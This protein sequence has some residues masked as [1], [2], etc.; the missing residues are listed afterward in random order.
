MSPSPTGVKPERHSSMRPKIGRILAAGAVALLC[1]TAAGS[2]ASAASQ[3]PVTGAGSTWSS[4]ALEQWI[5]DVN[6][7]GIR[8][9][10]AA[11]GSSDGRTQFKNGTVDFGVSEIPYGVTDNGAYEP[12]P[13]RP[14]AYMPIVAGGTSFMYHLHINGQQVT[15]LRLS[16]PVIAKIFTGNITKWNDPA[17]ASDNP[18]IILPGEPIIPIVRSDGSGTTAQLTTWM[19]KKYPDLWNP[20][21]AKAGRV[22]PCGITSTYPVVTGSGFIAQ[23]LS[24]G[25]AGYIT[26]SQSEGT[27]GY[28][29]TS[30]ADQQGYPVAKMLNAAGYYVAPTAQNVA[31]GLTAAQINTDPTSPNYL[32]QVLDGVY[33]NPDN[34]AYPL[35]S[36]S[37]MIIPTTLQ[38][39]MTA[40][41]GFTLGKFAYYF[42]CEG[43]QSMGDLGYSPLP[44]NLV[45]AAMDQVKKIPGVAVQDIDI[46]KCNNPTFDPSGKNLLAVTAPQPKPCDQF[47]VTMCPDPTGGAKNPTYVAAGP[48]PITTPAPH[49][50]KPGGGH[51]PGPT[52]SS[53]GPPSPGSPQTSATGTATPTSGPTGG[54]TSGTHQSAPPTSAGTSHTPGPA[55]NVPAASASPGGGSGGSGSDS[56]IGDGGGGSGQG[57]QQV[58]VGPQPRAV[59]VSLAV[60]TGWTL[61]DTL[62]VLA[63]VLLLLVTLA[64]PL[65]SRRLG[66]RRP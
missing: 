18:G 4:N 15:N 63:V 55:G 11:T 34:R 26:Q 52:K 12:P 21:C 65:L 25:V 56:I 36:Y 46:K 9:D 33:A 58:A 20:Y 7:Y 51:T 49:D 45:Q 35:S 32:T 19:S 48:A 5:G 27:I 14:Y 22:T 61:Q 13:S 42:L 41:K 40:N 10:F 60:S 59:P 6:Q 24:T 57:Q 66:R 37:Y 1:L 3:V 44:I 53:S 29:E 16:G 30:Y 64:P 31:V 17:I 47:G 43:Q 2:P 8:I 54:P 38:A 23:Q 39:P 62:M 28:V 50:T